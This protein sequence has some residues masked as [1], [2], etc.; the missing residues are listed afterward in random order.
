MPVRPPA[1]RTVLQSAAQANGN[2][3][4]A[5]C[6]GFGAACFQLTGTFSATV[7]FEG[8]LDNSNWVALPVID[9]NGA[10]QTTATATGIF[11]GPIAG[12]ASIRARV[13][14]YS[15]GSVTVTAICVPDVVPPP[16]TSATVTVDTEFPAAAALAD[17]TANPTTTLV[18]AMVHAL[19][20]TTWDRVTGDSSN[21][22]DVDVTRVSGTVTV[23]SELPAAAALADAAANPTT[24]T[25]GA[26]TLL[27]NGTTWDR[28]RGDT[29][30]G[31]DVDVTRVS[32]T[33]T[34]DSELP[35][36][37]ALADATANPTAP[38]VGS[39][40]HLYNGTTWD[41][42]PGDITNGLDVDVTRVSGTV[43]VDSELPSA[44][45][46]ADAAANPT[47]PTVGSAALMFNGTTWDRQRG[48]TTN[49]LDVDVT[50]VS[51]T[52]TVDSE[53]P[54]AAALADA[55]ANSTTPTVGAAAL[56]Y[57]GTTWDRVRGDT[58]NGVD[59]DVTREAGL[60]AT[61]PTGC[62]RLTL[63]NGSAT[64]GPNITSKR[65]TVVSDDGGATN[66]NTAVIWVAGSD[67]AANV[68]I[69]L[70]P[71]QSF[72]SDVSNANKLY[73]FV[74]AASHYI[75]LIVEQ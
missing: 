7:N 19:D 74:S 14:S 70:R 44:A 17:N 10:R 57:N 59:V 72:Q 35:T 11:W 66:G 29:S 68:G 38:A 31:L 24:P 65:V 50:R 30:N 71:G 36:A 9:T 45:A 51:G 61:I 26:A 52:V 41:R 23:D 48:D 33:V 8:T 20:G 47:T 1:F 58:T 27:F 53:L 37:A 40:A 12:M 21:G 34:V 64:Q 4:S 69:P 42:Q 2:G 46:L 13:S 43:T 25:V 5:E 18:G 67:V 55:A 6:M 3:T 54:T 75:T 63:N 39:M 56:L 22:L 49:G 62:N 16:A 60:Q 73:F 15:S 28:Q 32:G